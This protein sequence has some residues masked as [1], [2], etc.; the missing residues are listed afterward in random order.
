MYRHALLATA[1]ATLTLPAV[2]QEADLC[3]MTDKGGNCVRILACLGEEGRW[4]HGRAYGR[5]EGI[6]TGAVNDGVACSG[7]WVTQN[8]GGQGQAD[9]TCADGLQVTVL[10][11][12]QDVHTG[13]AVGQGIANT[14]D[15][16][17]AWSGNHVLTFFQDGTAGAEANLRC[18]ENV[19][20]L[21]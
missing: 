1:F 17:K 6:L 20:P 18:G 12:Y 4:F 21:R 15:L 10:Y 19:I 14:G 7:R 13:T 3:P 8:A 16:V 9:V 5:G 2:A 11:D